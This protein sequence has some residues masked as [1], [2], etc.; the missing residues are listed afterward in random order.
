MRGGYVPQRVP[1]SPERL[2]R[3]C[4]IRPALGE[5]HI[6]VFC[7]DANLKQRLAERAAVLEAGVGMTRKAERVEKAKRDKEE[8]EQHGQP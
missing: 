1:A 7:A 8:R 5:H 3:R 2:C 6:C 4:K